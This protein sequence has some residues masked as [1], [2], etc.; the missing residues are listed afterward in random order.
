LGYDDGD[1]ADGM[2]CTF[3]G[4][5]AVTERSEITAR[6]YR[7]FRCRDCGR[8]FNERSGGLLNRTSLPSDI[9]TFVVFCRLRYRLTLRD[10]SEILLLRGI[11][12]SHEAV[13]DWEM[14]LL[15]VMGEEL[16]KRR[17]GRQRGP[18]AS[19]GCGA[20][21]PP[22]SKAPYCGMQ[23]SRPKHRVPD[24]RRSSA[25]NAQTPQ[26]ELS[27]AD[28][29]HQLDAGDRERRILEPLE[30]EHHSNALLHAPMVLLNQV[31]QVFRRSAASC[32]R[33]ASHRLSARAPRDEMRHSRPASV[34]AGHTAELL[35]ALRERLGGRDVAVGTQPE[36]DRPAG[37][38]SAD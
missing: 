21:L 11:E 36:V 29:M 22:R 5:E 8:Q 6:G 17:H 19:W 1:R 20:N 28:P 10:L 26:P 33:A 38:V 7:R 9:I 35:I 25:L 37:P 24:C 14:K 13:R 12:V 15:P 31:V 23:T 34:S 3:C 16:R 30:A 2:N 27:L 32:P 18:G 4:S